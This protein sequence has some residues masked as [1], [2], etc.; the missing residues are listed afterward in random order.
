M[1][2]TT[3][4][5]FQKTNRV[6]LK[7]YNTYILKKIIASGCQICWANLNWQGNGKFR[8]YWIVSIMEGFLEEGSGWTDVRLKG[9]GFSGEWFHLT[10]HLDPA[11]QLTFSDFQE[12]VSKELGICTLLSLGKN[13]WVHQLAMFF[14]HPGFWSLAWTLNSPG[15]RGP[16]RKAPSTSLPPQALTSLTETTETL[17]DGG[18]STER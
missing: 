16:A 18:K 12:I 15:S 3:I 13:W 10:V 2:F 4:K 9:Q 17:V 1:Y 8:Y 14:H 7:L 11:S 6:I 5:N